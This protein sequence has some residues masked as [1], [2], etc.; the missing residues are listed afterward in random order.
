MNRPRPPPDRIAPIVAVAITCSV[1]VRKPPV[2]IDDARGSS[3][4]RRICRSRSP[5]PRPASM[6]SRS[7]DRS[8]AKVLTSS[9]GMARNV[10]ARKI[11][12]KFR[13]NVGE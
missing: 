6:S 12:R 9:G 1:A 11:G 10:I 7:T 3:M 13:P 4:S 8:P 5:M 2:M